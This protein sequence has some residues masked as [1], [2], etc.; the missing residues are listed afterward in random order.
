MGNLAVVLKLDENA[1]REFVRF[2]EVPESS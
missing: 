1:K 2:K